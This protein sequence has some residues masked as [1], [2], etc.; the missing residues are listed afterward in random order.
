LNK[1]TFTKGRRARIVFQVF[2]AYV[3]LQLSWWARLLIES[4]SKLYKVRTDPHLLRNEETL[5]QAQEELRGSLAM[6][7]GEGAIF[8]VLFIVGMIL[9]SRLLRA[10][11]YRLDRERSFLLAV[12]HELKTPIASIRLAI[13]TVD[14]LDLKGEQKNE[15]INEARMGADRLE[16]RIGD[17]L[18]ATRLNLPDA[19]VKSPFDLADAIVEVINEFETKNSSYEIVLDT[20]GYVPKH[21]EGD[22][23]MWQLCFTNLVENAT[24][25]GPKDGKLEISLRNVGRGVKMVF[26]D[27]GPGIPASERSDVFNS[28]YR[29]DRDKNIAGTGLGL[30]LVKRIV[31]MHGA[32]ITIKPGEKEG[33]KFVISWEK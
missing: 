28:F 11:E 2:A 10:E 3:F 32:K 24:K 33:A 22:V 29:L 23:K 16:R 17:I 19:L 30:H 13:D 8:A 7:M 31:K 9:V 4:A 21:M 5:L 15:V 26:K 6:I 27:D 14:R 12:T 20:E 25:Y 18:E 1:K